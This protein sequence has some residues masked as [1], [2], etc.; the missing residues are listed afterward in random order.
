MI[1]LIDTTGNDCRVALARPDGSIIGTGHSIGNRQQAE[2]LIPLVRTLVKD[3]GINTPDRIAVVTGPGSFT[4]IRIGLAAAK[5][6]AA[7]W[8]CDCIG[9]NQFSIYG[10]LPV[11]ETVPSRTKCVVIIESLRHELF[12]QPW[13]LGE[14]VA[15]PFMAAP[16]E[17]TAWI[18]AEYSSGAENYPDNILVL[19][20]N[21]AAR[22]M[23]AAKSRA[24]IKDEVTDQYWLEQFALIA[25]MDK[26]VA[27][28]LPRPCY[29][30][31][32]DVTIC[33]R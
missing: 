10:T 8:G 21:A 29:I 1:L 11:A 14:P 30:R 26:H 23:P 7:G 22:I 13:L 2:C 4:G 25:A 15:D 20:G 24:V 9:I 33:P 27:H 31:P 19:R 3:A 28:T 16:D 5:G 12:V 6:L 18:D 17:I 32:P